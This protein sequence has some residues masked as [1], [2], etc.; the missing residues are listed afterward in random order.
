MSEK[1][2]QG[3][4]KYSRDKYVARLNGEVTKAYATWHSML[5]RC[6][7]KKY[8][9]K[10]PTYIGCTVDERWYDFQAFASWYNSNYYEMP[11]LGRTELDKDILI[12]GNRIYSPERCVF[13]PQS[14]NSLL[15]KRQNKRGQF[16]IGVYFHKPTCKFKAQCNFGNGKPQ[17]LGCFD[18]PEEAFQVY[19]A[20]KEGFI[21]QIAEKYKHMIPQVLY[22]ALMNYRVDITD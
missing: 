10:K 14:I 15:V 8:Q 9:E 1:L 22:V 20:A 6:N 7:D 4:G 3:I 19:K 2:V 16:P 13:V 5:R 11:L 21:K 18:S 17:H 12:K